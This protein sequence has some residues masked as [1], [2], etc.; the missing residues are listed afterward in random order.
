LQA[1]N[2]G[3]QGSRKT[4]ATTLLN[5]SFLRQ[6]LT[7]GDDSIGR[8]LQ[9]IGKLLGRP[10]AEAPGLD[11]KGEATLYRSRPPMRNDQKLV[12]LRH[13]TGKLSVK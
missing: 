11:R 5:L 2:E 7:G 6:R 8:S 10:L 12:D 3:K 9:L 4:N 13:S 1:E